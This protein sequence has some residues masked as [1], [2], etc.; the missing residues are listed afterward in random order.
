MRKAISYLFPP[1]L[2]QQVNERMA[3]GGYTSEDE[4]LR[5]AFA[6]LTWEEQEL[7]AVMQAVE[8]LDN[9]DEGI[10]LDAAFDQLRQKH[11]MR[12]DG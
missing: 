12:S 6:A 11:A 8:A 2:Q 10:E 3:R 1:D 5:D 4:V 7:D 9:G